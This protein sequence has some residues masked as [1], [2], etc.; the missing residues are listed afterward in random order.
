MEFL[1]GLMLALGV[2]LGGTVAGL[3]RERAF[4]TAV[5]LAVGTYY[6]LFAVMGGSSEA[7]IREVLAF[8][9]LTAVAVVG[10]RRNF[11]LVVVALAGHGLFDVFHRHLIVN[12]GVPAFWPM[13]CMSYD[14][15]AALYLAWLMHRRPF[16]AP[17]PERGC[18]IGGCVTVGTRR[19]GRAAGEPRRELSQARA[20]A[21]AVA[22]VNVG[23]RPGPLAHA[24]L[25][26]ATA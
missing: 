8:A 6:I 15:T 3:D 14:V 9:V 11:W 5:A 23:A 17:L 20:R 10:F 12:D 26:A 22:D 21:C 25:G 16:S 24:V 1:V 19:R 4:Y 18:P 13:F 2:S 7:L